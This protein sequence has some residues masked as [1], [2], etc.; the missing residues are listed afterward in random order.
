M[1]SQI[2]NFTSKFCYL[3]TNVL[4]RVVFLKKIRMNG[5]RLFS[6]DYKQ[7]VHLNL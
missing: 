6:I 1:Y 3:K 2:I 4:E 7:F 5:S